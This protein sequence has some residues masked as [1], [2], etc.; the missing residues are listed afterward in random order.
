MHTTTAIIK[1]AIT[2]TTGL[3]NPKRPVELGNPNT[4]AE[5]KLCLFFIPAQEIVCRETEISSYSKFWLNTNE[6]FRKLLSKNSKKPQFLTTKNILFSK[7][8][9][10][11]NSRYNLT[12][13]LHKNLKLFTAST[14]IN[15]YSTT[16]T[17]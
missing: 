13:K 11:I 17:D 5:A 8:T 3:G 15:N 10:S 14:T 7:P 1:C 16:S 9:N 6:F 12:L 4:Y 2:V